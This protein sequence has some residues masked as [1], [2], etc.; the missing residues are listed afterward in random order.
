[1]VLPAARSHAGEREPLPVVLLCDGD[2]WFGRLG[3]RHT[4]DAMIADG[5]CRRSPCCRPTRW[6]GAPGGA[7]SAGG[8]SSCPSSRT[9]CCRGPPPSDR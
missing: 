6:T 9:S 2:M 3:L 8:R 1:M 5:C 4:L 7:N